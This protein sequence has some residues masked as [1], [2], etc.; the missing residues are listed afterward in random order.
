MTPLPWALSALAVWRLE[1]EKHF[2]T[3]R[4]GEGALRVGGRWSPAGRP[5]IYTS[6]DPA[7]AILEVAVHKGFDILD[8]DPHRLLQ[9][10]IKDPPSAI[11]VVR[12]EDV[13]NPNWLRP[14][15]L[16]PNQQ[17]FGDALLQAYGLVI[18]PS[19]VSTHSWNLVIDVVAGAGRFELASEERFALDTRLAARPTGPKAA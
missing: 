17:A 7:T 16:S 13:P 12:P 1:R 19:A 11:K 2:A 10:E 5:A 3:W 15:T 6:L 4:T 18:F 9:L 14:G 8:T